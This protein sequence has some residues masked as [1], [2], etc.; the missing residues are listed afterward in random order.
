MAGVKG[1]EPLVQGSKPCALPLG[2]TP[3][4]GLA[5]AAGLEPARDPVNSRAPYQLGYAPT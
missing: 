4:S 5:G 1:F 2:H 3:V